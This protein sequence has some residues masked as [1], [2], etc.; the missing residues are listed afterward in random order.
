MTERRNI[1]MRRKGNHLYSVSPYEYEALEAYPEDKDLWVT[2]HRKRSMVHN[3]KYWAMLTK[4]IAS[5]ATKY[6]SI[7]AL[8]RALKYEMGY[9]KPIRKLSGD[10]VYEADSTA[11]DKM[12]QTEFN[13]FFDEAMRL[14]GEHFAINPDDL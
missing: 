8:H 13:K 2:I 12:D 5:G 11:F 6:H 10:I 4:V 1:I 9:V 7:G 3:A 14:L